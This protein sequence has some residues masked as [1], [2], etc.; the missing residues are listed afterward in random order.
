MPSSVRSR[1]KLGILKLQQRRKSPSLSPSAPPTTTPPTTSSTTSPTT[2]RTTPPSVSPSVPSPPISSDDPW[3]RFKRPSMSPLHASPIS[4]L[5]H[6]TKNYTQQSQASFVTTRSKLTQSVMVNWMYQEFI[7]G[8]LL[9]V[10]ISILLFAVIFQKNYFTER[11]VINSID[12]NVDVDTRGN[13]VVRMSSAIKNVCIII[14]TFTFVLISWLWNNMEYTL[15][16]DQLLGV[17]LYVMRFLIISALV[18]IL[19]IVYGIVTMTSFG[20]K[21]TLAYNY[22]SKKSGIYPVNSFVANHIYKTS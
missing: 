17:W 9:Y 10:S 5:S 2:P 6:I 20:D 16:K 13:D 7:H 3:K 11:M 14:L 22:K 12:S 21:Y 19:Y 15:Y 18:S 8:A 4:A 1:T